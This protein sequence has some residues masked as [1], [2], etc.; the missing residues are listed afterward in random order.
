[1]P[2]AA[3]LAGDESIDSN[4]QYIKSR[5]REKGRGRGEEEGDRWR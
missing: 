2:G 3:V 1:M 4:S 5:E